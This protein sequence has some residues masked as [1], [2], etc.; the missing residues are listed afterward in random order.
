MRIRKCNSCP[1]N[2]WVE[3]EIYTFAQYA[4]VKEETFTRNKPVHS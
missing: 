2:T 1:P 3:L 4:K